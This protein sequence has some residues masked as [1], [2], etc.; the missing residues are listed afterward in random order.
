MAHTGIVHYPEPHVS[1][2]PSETR[3]IGS[4]S[5]A[6]ALGL[7]ATKDS[8]GLGQRLLKGGTCLAVSINFVI[9]NIVS[10]M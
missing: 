3:L 5:S 7:H 6:A 2:A 9:P 10:S 4:I 1:D 8:S